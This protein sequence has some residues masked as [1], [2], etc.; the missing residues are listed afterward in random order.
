M[1][2]SRH[3]SNINVR[4]LGCYNHSRKTEESQVYRVAFRR[5]KSVTSDFGETPQ[6]SRSA[7]FAAV[8]ST[9]PFATVLST[10]PE[11]HKVAVLPTSPVPAIF[12]GTTSSANTTRLCKCQ[13]SIFV[14]RKMRIVKS[15]LSKISDKKLQTNVHVKP[16]MFL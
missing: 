6:S 10:S 13:N 11:T 5:L 16:N 2:N 1:S 7:N 9:S 14:N 4:R 12:A 8:L 3:Q 15:W